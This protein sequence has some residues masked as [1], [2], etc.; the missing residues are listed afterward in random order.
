MNQ[1]TME[2]ANSWPPWYLQEKYPPLS[3]P[4]ILHLSAFFLQPNDSKNVTRPQK[5]TAYFWCQEN[6]QQ[7]ISRPVK[8]SDGIKSKS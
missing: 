3:S 5:Y 7:R 1:G 4:E 2:L 6:D 8:C